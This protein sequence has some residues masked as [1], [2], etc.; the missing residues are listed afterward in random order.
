MYGFVY[1][2]FLFLRNVYFAAETL[3]I[4][5][6]EDWDHGIAGYYLG[7]TDVETDGDWKYAKLTS[8]NI[9]IIE[10][11]GTATEIDLNALDFGGKI[12]NIGG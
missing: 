10:Y 6:E 3:P 1:K 8:G 5:L 4:R 2:V 12:V 7:V 11:I 9:A